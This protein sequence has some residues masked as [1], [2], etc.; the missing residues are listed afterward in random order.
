[1]SHQHEH[2]HEPNPAPVMPDDAGS[3]ALAEALRSSF[4]IVKIAMM[5]M[6]VA[7]FGS[8]FFTVGPSEK[9]VILRFG[10]LVGEGQKALLSSG[11]LYWSYPY[12]IDQVVKIPIAEIQSVESTMGW[13]FM[14]REQEIAYKTTGFEPPAGPSL[15]PAID[16]YAITAD[17]NI[18]H[19]RATLNYHIADPIHAVFGFSADASFTYSLAGVSNA[20]QN[21][22]NNA[23]LYTAARFNVDDILTRNVAGFQDAVLQRVSNLIEQEQLGIVIDN[24]VVR[25]VPPRQLR[26][27]FDQVTTARENRNKL[28]NDAHSYE[29]QVLIQSGAQAASITNAAAADRARYVESI[30]AE[31]KRFN[32]LLPKYES[33]PNLFAQ[34]TFLQA[35]GPALTNAEKW[36]QPITENGKSREIRLLLNREPPQPKPAPAN[37]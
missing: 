1:M 14:S 29:S 36:I 3:R 19:T 17:R 32:D 10:K 16:G 6:V 21:V 2:H 33:N 7:F 35:V 18:I 26:N 4:T 9:A 15:N 31:A 28:L 11:R 27:V 13:Y 12:P 24:C 8:G 20:A 5:L 25:S 34:Q 23:L 37:P 22:L 30:T